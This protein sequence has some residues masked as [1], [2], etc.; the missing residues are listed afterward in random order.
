MVHNA[1]CLARLVE[2]G[3]EA[4]PC[5]K[6]RVVESA[7]Q[8]LLAAHAKL[9]IHRDVSPGNILHFPGDAYPW[10][11]SDFGLV[12]RF[13]GHTTEVVTSG[14]A[15]GT[16]YFS[17]PEA[18]IDPHRMDQRADIFSLG[19]VIGWLVS[20]QRPRRSSPRFFRMARGESWLPV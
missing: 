16:V 5:E 3:S 10:K 9:L 2:R 17:P 13:P 18:E 11:L 20:G 15:L 19:Q 12:R 1:S 4:D 7:A 6:F 8:A 14:A